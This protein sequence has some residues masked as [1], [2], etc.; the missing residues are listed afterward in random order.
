[1][2]VNGSESELRSFGVELFNQWTAMWNGDLSIASRIMAAEFTL[3][4]AQAGTEIADDVR[5][6]AA[7]AELITRWHGFRPGIKFSAEGEAVVDLARV[8]DLPAGRVA[9]PYLA[10]FVDPAGQTVA[11]SGIDMFA[12]RGG[13]IIEVWSVSSGV[14]G[15]TF[16]ADARGQ[17][18]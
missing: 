17:R 12:V 1:M 18:G 9:R 11:R 5:S 4:Y 10:V 6:P 16:Y 14:A 7:L 13:R 2:N 8:D 3:R 15:R